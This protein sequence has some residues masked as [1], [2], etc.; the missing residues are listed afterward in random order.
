MS[1]AVSREARGGMSGHVASVKTIEVQRTGA[2]EMS[3]PMGRTH[4][5]DAV[6][7]EMGSDLVEVFACLE[8]VRLAAATGSES[9]V[10]RAV[11]GLKPLVARASLSAKA[12]FAWASRIKRFQAR[13]RN[14]LAP[15][16]RSPTKRKT[17]SPSRAQMSLPIGPTVEIEDQGW[18]VHERPRPKFRAERGGRTEDGR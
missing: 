2:V 16:R 12:P 1:D 17:I 7:V 9:K 11:R 15:T 5:A 8:A 6:S 14:G 13:S 4:V 10:F 18:P 3:T